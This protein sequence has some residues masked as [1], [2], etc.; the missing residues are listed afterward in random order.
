MDE[1]LDALATYRLT[2]LVIEDKILEP[3]RDRLFDRYPPSTQIGYLLTCPWCVSMWAG[4]AVV[5]SR[6]VSPRL[7]P[8]AA[9]ALAFSAVTGLVAEHEEG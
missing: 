6:R 5:A 9:R 7:W 4:I 2:K 8:A 1:L 3:I